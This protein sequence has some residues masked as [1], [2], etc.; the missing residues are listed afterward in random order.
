MVFLQSLNHWK[1]H[2]FP[3]WEELCD[4]V[5]VLTLPMRVK[6]RGVN[7]R[8]IIIFRGPAGWGEFS[9]F[10]EYQPAEAASWLLAGIEAAWLGFP[11]PARQTVPVNAT[12][13]AVAPE[14]VESVLS[15]YRGEIK[16]LKIK[17]AE[18]GQSLAEDIARLRLA[19][20]LLPTAGLKV[21]ANM[22]YTHQQAVQALEAFEEFDL[23][24]AEQPVA[25]VEGLAQLREEMRNRGLSTLIA[26][27]ESVRKAEDPLRV[28]RWGAADLLVVKAAPLGGV[29]SA[30]AICEEAGLPAVISSALDSSVGISMGLALAASLPELPFGCGLATVSLMQEDVT[31]NSLIA[32]NG[33]IQVGKVVPDAHRLTR[34]AA[35]SERRAWWLARLRTCYDLLAA[36]LGRL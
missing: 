33:E 2:R 31:A 26:A 5:H 15:S 27:D 4:Q 20:Q 32:H 3:S 22:G 14:Q 25:S 10:T 24:Y 30:L 16:E 34:L 6:F 8:E 17:V 1:S 13:P 21:D 9:P 18:K 19:R 11:E 12:L 35:P 28:A 36:E 29:R 23:L 7:K